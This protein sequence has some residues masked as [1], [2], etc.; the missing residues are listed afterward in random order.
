MP[1]RFHATKGFVID[2]D[3][4]MSDHQDVVI[5]DEQSSPV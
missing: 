5:Y 4:Q 2:A 3:N 1:K